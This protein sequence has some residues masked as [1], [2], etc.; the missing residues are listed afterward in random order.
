M[1]TF[2]YDKENGYQQDNS[3]YVYIFIE[4]EETAQIT[5]LY[6]LSYLTI[7]IF[8]YVSFIHETYSNCTATEKTCPVICNIKGPDQPAHPRS[9]INSFV[10]FFLRRII[11]RL[12]LCEK[13]SIFYLA[14]LAKGTS[15]R[16]T[17]VG[18]PEDRFSRVVACVAC[19][20]AL[21]QI[22]QVQQIIILKT[23]I[24]RRLFIGYIDGN[25]SI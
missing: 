15:L 24:M 9:L 2:L 20:T 22:F 3:W 8:L 7:I 11:P 4:N 19:S 14:C 25:H 13:N 21:G 17:F 16:L 12:A 1:F 18:N 5:I 23:N 6:E 10:V